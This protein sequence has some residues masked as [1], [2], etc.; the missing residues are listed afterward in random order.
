M[1]EFRTGNAVVRIHGTYEREKLEAATV[2]F[3]KKVTRCR[4]EKSKTSS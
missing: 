2:N 3:M 4:K 1:K